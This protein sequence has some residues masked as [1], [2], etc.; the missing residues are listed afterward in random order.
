MVL[1]RGAPGGTFARPPHCTAIL[2]LELT[3]RSRR[4]GHCA[5]TQVVGRFGHLRK[6][7]VGRQMALFAGI[8]SKTIILRQWY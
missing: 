8:R 2:S 7:P 4:R 3:L 1:Q 6:A 5:I